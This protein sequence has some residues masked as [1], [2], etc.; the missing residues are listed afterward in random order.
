VWDE[1]LE[2]DVDAQVLAQ[3]D[4]LLLVEVLQLPSSFRG[5]RQLPQN[6]KAAGGGGGGALGM[7]VAWGFL[8]LRA[9]GPAEVGREGRRLALQLYRYHTPGRMF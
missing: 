3:G 6:F 2:L 5:Y 9:L 8:R 7:G 1:D 4:A